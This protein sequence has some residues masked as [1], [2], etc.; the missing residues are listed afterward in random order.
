MCLNECKKQKYI[1]KAIN[2]VKIQF[3]IRIDENS[4][5]I[6]NFVFKSFG[7]YTVVI[8]LNNAIKVI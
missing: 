7:K 5:Y 4:T 8:K 2:G 6:K 1:V 3:N